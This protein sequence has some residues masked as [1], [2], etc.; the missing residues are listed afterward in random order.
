MTIDENGL[1]N[2]VSIDR[3]TRAPNGQISLEAEEDAT[4]A[5]EQTPPTEETTA[6]TP[7]EPTDD[8]STSGREYV[9]ERVMAHKESPEGRLYRVRWHGYTA[10][11]DTWEPRRHLPANFVKRYERRVRRKTFE[12]ME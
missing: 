5:N 2:T 1:D 10:R 6:E 4:A 7:Q 3:V 9:I 12:D 11:D 8:A